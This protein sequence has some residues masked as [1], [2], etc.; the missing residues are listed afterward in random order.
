MGMNTLNSSRYR[1]SRDFIVAK[2]ARA[3]L[4]QKAVAE[5]LGMSRSFVSRMESTGRIYVI[6]IP[7]LGEILGFDPDELFRKLEKVK[8]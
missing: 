5:R 4:T 2:R 3:G 1:A 7:E 8:R 6:D